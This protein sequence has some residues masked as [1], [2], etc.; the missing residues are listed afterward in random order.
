MEAVRRLPSLR[1]PKAGRAASFIAVGVAASLAGAASSTWFLLWWR[2][3]PQ[4]RRWRYTQM[5][6]TC[7]GGG[8]QK[9]AGQAYAG[10]FGTDIGGTLA[11]LVYLQP[12][13]EQNPQMGLI[14]EMTDLRFSCRYLGGVLRFLKLPT[15]DVEAVVGAIAN[16]NVV[17]DGM[18][19]MYAT[20]GGAFK[21]RDEVRKNAR[22]PHTTPPRAPPN[23]HAT[24][25]ARSNGGSASISSRWTRWTR[26]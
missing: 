23:T 19:Q 21:F 6:T 26:W 2:R 9:T 22:T 10:T 11:K 8:G 3:L 1:L 15:D 4:W 12:A 18:R 24:P 17:D 5:V 16:A 7:L 25:R 20:G 14:A 13:K